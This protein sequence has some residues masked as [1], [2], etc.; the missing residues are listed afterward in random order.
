MLFALMKLST[1]VL[2]RRIMK[3]KRFFLLILLVPSI[4]LGAGNE[5]IN[6]MPPNSP[7]LFYPQAQNMWKNEL[8]N[9]MKRYV[10][11]D[12]VHSGGLHG[13]SGSCTSSSFSLEGF[14]SNGNRVTAN[15][16]GGQTSINYG[17]PNIGANCS[18]DVCWVAASTVAQAT[19]PSSDFQRVGTS[20]LYANCS[21]DDEPTWPADTVKLMK[22]T[23]SSNA[24]TAVEDLRRPS[25]YARNGTYDI[26]DPLYGAI[27]DNSTDIAPA[28]TLAIAAAKA[29]RGH[30]ITI[31]KGKYVV[32]SVI[33]VDAGVTI[34]GE[35]W[36]PSIAFNQIDEAN[37]TFIRHTSTSANAI[38]LNHSGSGV[39]NISFYQDH[40]APGVGWAPVDYPF[41]ILINHETLAISDITIENIYF[42]NINKGIAQVSTDNVN[43]GRVHIYNIFGQFFRTGIYLDYLL[44]ITRVYNIHMWPFWSGDDSVM[45]WQA[46]NLTSIQI[47]RCDGC[48]LENVFSFGSYYG[49]HFADNPHGGSVGFSGKTLQFDGANYGI[50]VGQSGSYGWMLNVGMTSHGRPGQENSRGIAILGTSN[51]WTFVNSEITNTGNECVVSSGTA[52]IVVLTNIRCVN[53]NTS[54]IGAF[55]LLAA[56]NGNIF[57]SGFQFLAPHP[58]HVTAKYAGVFQYQ[59]MPGGAIFGTSGEFFANE[60]SG[61]PT[62]SF[63]TGSFVTFDPSTQKYTIWAAGNTYSTGGVKKYLCVQDGVLTVG[64]TCP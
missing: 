58:S 32:N 16:S 19:I 4:S 45:N 9:V 3:M 38:W 36:S 11:S 33:F 29:Q 28:A 44:D 56:D 34:Q 51:Y 42:Y 2:F 30:V 48:Y 20:N 46:L 13:T 61:I 18:N 22:V 55:G 62:I 31:P 37:G 60:I 5:T 8:P 15:G 25:S 23:L 39:R 50:A 54:G 27:A 1:K 24:I 64:T 43:S 10:P 35:G 14:T 6:T 7:N 57:V 17:A 59:T 40:P 21:S 41:V 63:E 52:V 49:L 26:T 12:F 53:Y 47:N